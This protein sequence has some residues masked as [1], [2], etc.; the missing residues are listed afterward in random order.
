MKKYQP[1][2]YLFYDRP[3]NV[4]IRVELK[5]KID[6]RLLSETANKVIKRYPYFSVRAVVDEDGKYV[7]EH[8][9][10][11]LV[12]TETR[13]PNY[14]LGAEEVNFHMAYIDYME[15]LHHNDDRENLEFE[16][17]QY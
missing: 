17:I 8:N 13:F 15:K 5:E 4:R 10:L 16:R 3:Y 11:P 14:P 1:E 7:I 6:G 2:S 12:V 9:S